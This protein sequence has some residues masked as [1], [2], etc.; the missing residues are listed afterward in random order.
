MSCNVSPRSVALVYF[1]P[2]SAVGDLLS[3][4]CQTTGPI[5]DPKTVFHG[6]GHK[7]SEYI[8]KYHL[9]VT[10]DVTGHT[11]GHIFSLSGID[12]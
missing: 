10:D 2:L 6:G 3:A 9:K 7:L 12:G 8:M 11:K 1:R 4:I 5:L